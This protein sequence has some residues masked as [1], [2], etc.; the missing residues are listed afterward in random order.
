M[1]TR[2]SLTVVLMLCLR[3]SCAAQESEK[4][5]VNLCAGCHGEAAKGTDR[6]PALIDNRK[7]RNR[8]E[9]QISEII[10]GGTPGGMPPFSLAEPELRLLARWIRSMNVSAYSIQPAGDT[11][12]GEQFFFG[13]GRCGSCHMIAGRGKANGPDLSDIGRQLTLRDLERAVDDPSSRAG[14]RSASSCP[15]R[16]WCPENPW[17][18]WNVR[19]KDGTVLRGF[20]R[21]QGKHHLQLQTFDGR[22]HLMRD[23]EYESATAEK[24][25]LMPALQASAEE[26]RDLFAYLAARV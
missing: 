24:V 16:A 22:F 23:T 10:R 3:L 2:M 19:M 13:K 11:V 18:V 8:S 7:L 1:P 14:N 25:S 15:G 17:A 5:F 6:G 9:D 20:A 21:G 26:R 4:H 12:G